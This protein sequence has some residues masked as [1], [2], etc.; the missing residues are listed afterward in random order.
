MIGGSLKSGS[1]NNSSNNKPN[2]KPDNISASKFNGSLMV[3]LRP[4]G[5]VGSSSHVFVTP[6]TSLINQYQNSL[7]G[8]DNITDQMLNFANKIGLDNPDEAAT[9]NASNLSDPVVQQKISTSGF[10]TIAALQNLSAQILVIA[11]TYPKEA[12]AGGANQIH[13]VLVREG[14]KSIA[15]LIESAT[16]STSEPIVDYGDYI[17]REQDQL[18]NIQQ[19]I[20]QTSVNDELQKYKQS[21]N[22]PVLPSI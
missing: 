22:K 14:I 12:Q 4:S 1:A 11:D 10:E 13:S 6:L 3:T 19:E 18:A 8:Q 17:V 9:F 21:T 16:L 15:K 20:S 2:N 5:T 7:Q